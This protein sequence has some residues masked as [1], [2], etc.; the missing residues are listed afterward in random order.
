MAW[1]KEKWVIYYFN[2]HNQ[3][4]FWNGDEWA[5]HQPKLFLCR[6]WAMEQLNKWPESER[7]G[8]IIGSWERD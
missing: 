1:N 4:V 6:E 5:H 2:A 8:K 7:E 3:F